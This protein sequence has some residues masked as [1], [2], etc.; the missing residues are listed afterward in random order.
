MYGFRPIDE[1]WVSPHQPAPH[2]LLGYN[3]RHLD[4]A[5]PLPLWVLENIRLRLIR[6]VHPVYA[7]P[8]ADE[9]LMVDRAYEAAAVNWAIQ[10]LRETNSEQDGA[11]LDDRIRRARY[12]EKL[13]LTVP[14]L[15]R[16]KY[17]QFVM[18]STNTVADRSH[19]RFELGG[20]LFAMNTDLS[21]W[22]DRPAEWPQTEDVVRI[23]AEAA[24]R[25]LCIEC[26]ANRCGEMQ[27]AKK[28]ARVGELVGSCRGGLVGFGREAAGCGSS[29]QEILR[30]QSGAPQTRSRVRGVQ[31]SR[32]LCREV[33][34]KPVPS[35]SRGVH[36]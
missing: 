20:C 10:Y 29:R 2:N 36:R 28:C 15:P 21:D 4:E 5:I 7:P 18:Q 8:D 16:S 3:H 35:P 27:R 1:F 9:D 11:L 32:L 14:L 23:V 19:I 30:R 33:L 31:V 22:N 25:R 26:R 24:Q 13:G 17:S 12:S 34:G 6:P